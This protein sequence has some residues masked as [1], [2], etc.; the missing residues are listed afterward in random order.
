ML[1]VF[2]PIFGADIKTVCCSNFEVRYKVEKFAFG[3]YFVKK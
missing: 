3:E 2:S 1:I